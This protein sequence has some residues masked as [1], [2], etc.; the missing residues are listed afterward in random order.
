V[1]LRRITILRRGDAVQDE[2][3]VTLKILVPAIIAGDIEPD[4]GIAEIEFVFRPD[5]DIVDQLRSNVG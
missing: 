3:N 2:R 4:R 5:L 1:R